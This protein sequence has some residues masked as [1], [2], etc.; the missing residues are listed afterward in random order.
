MKN[1]ILILTAA[2][3]LAACGT[4]EGFGNDV[5]SGARTVQGWL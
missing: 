3:A 2:A 4:V 5:S 1:L